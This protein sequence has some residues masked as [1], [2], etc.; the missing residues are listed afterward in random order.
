MDSFKVV[1]TN[2]A[3][4]VFEAEAR[5]LK[6]V[7]DVP[8]GLNGT[9][10][11]MLPPEMLLAALGNCLGMVIALTC[12]AKDVPYAGMVVTTTADAVDGGSRLDN[13]KVEVQMPGELDDRARRLVESAKE[14]CKVGHTLA[15]GA[16]VEEIIL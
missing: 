8:A 5:G 11:A 4:T 14:L 12:R 7:C 15:H 6:A 13:F 16:K 9:D 3:P 1:S 10:T 2:T